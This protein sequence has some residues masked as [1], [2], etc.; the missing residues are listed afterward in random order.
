M[1]DYPATTLALNKG[2][3]YVLLTIPL[4]LRKHF[5]GRKQ[6]KRSTGTNDLS[7]AKRKQH[8]ISAELYSELD[9]CKPDPRDIISELLGWIGDLEEVQ[10]L[11]DNGDL[12]G[13][14]MAH[15]DLTEAIVKNKGSQR[16]VPVHSKLTWVRTG[17][18]GQMFPQFTRDRDGKAQRRS[19]M[20][21]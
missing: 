9:K 18:R 7:I 5:N 10:R 15:F 6:L 2:K 19:Q 11:E 13:V 14:I 16:R 12:E 3:Y 20:V 1:S 17:A 8:N 4:E 21:R